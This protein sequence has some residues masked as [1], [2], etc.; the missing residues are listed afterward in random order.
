MKTFVRNMMQ[1]SKLHINLE[2]LYIIFC[3]CCDFSSCGIAHMFVFCIGVVISC[4]QFN[5]PL[6][7]F[8]PKCA[9]LFSRGTRTHPYRIPIFF[10]LFLMIILCTPIP[11]EGIQIF[12]IFCEVFLTFFLYISKLFSGYILICVLRRF[13]LR[14]ATL[15][16]GNLACCGPFMQK[17]C[18]EARTAI[19]LCVEPCDSS[20]WRPHTKSYI[21]WFF[22]YIWSQQGQ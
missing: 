15:L 2:Y 3:S 8:S 6:S 5:M 17:G 21:T 14:M 7:S 1:C 11:A 20:G 9:Y 13:I 19:V 12:H 22:I 4:L 10:T 16:F 18:L